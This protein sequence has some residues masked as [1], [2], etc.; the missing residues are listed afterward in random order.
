MGL[1]P[2]FSDQVLPFAA[3]AHPGM[4]GAFAIVTLPGLAHDVGYVEGPAG[5]IYL[6]EQDHVRRCTMRFAVL[7]SL[8][9]SAAESADLIS[10]TLARYQ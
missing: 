6:E 3:G 2:L 9:L 10:I 8:A 4:E 5:S 1:A 7:S